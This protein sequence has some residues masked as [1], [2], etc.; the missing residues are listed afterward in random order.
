[1]YKPRS[2]STVK[3]DKL[4]QEEYKLTTPAHTD[5]VFLTILTTF[6]YPGLQVLHE[7]KYRS[8]KPIKNHLVVNLGDVLSRATNFKL[9]ATSH[10]VLDIGI[11][12]YSSPFFLEPSYSTVVPAN[13][14]NQEEEAVENP[15]T[16]G[17]WLINK[18]VNTYAEWK[19]FKMPPK[20]PRV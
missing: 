1:M 4:N 13:L 6:G 15:V 14:L 7:G 17:E 2:K 12:R 18:L 10:R 19:N 5:S 9:K 8:V 20:K 16:Y 11:E 3:Q